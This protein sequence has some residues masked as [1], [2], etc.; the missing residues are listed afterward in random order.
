MYLSLLVTLPQS[1]HA[2]PKRNLQLKIVLIALGLCA[3]APASGMYCEA[4]WTPPGGATVFY[5]E[6]NPLVTT[7]V[8]FWR[9]F[10]MNISHP[11]Q[12]SHSPIAWVGCKYDYY[13]GT[14]H[15]TWQ[16]YY[17]QN[18]NGVPTWIP[19]ALDRCNFGCY[20]QTPL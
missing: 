10:G 7:P 13:P 8:S 6:G 17:S 19:Y 14:R 20:S 12:N 1:R 4:T 5:C 18:V 11:N 9:K 2:M 15:V 3:A 16:T